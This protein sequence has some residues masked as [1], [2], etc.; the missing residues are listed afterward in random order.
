[1]KRMLLMALA[2]LTMNLAQASSLPDYP[3]IFQVGTARLDVAPDIAVISITVSSRGSDASKALAVVNAGVSDAFRVLY[4]AEIPQ[5]DIVSTDIMRMLEQASSDKTSGP[6]VY[7]V[8]RNVRITVRK[9]AAWAPL[10]SELAVLK[11]VVNLESEFNVSGQDAIENALALKAASDARAK[12]SRLAET[13]NRKIVAVMAVSEVP[14]PSLERTL[15]SPDNREF[16]PPA[17]IPPTEY[18][19][20]VRAPASI[21]LQKA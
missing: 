15:I 21:P 19:S 18:S 17:F 1:M 20:A 3:F 5:S 8:R 11:N 4:K 13:L 12:A 9:L 6:P 10:M 16:S 2:S 7:I 14:F